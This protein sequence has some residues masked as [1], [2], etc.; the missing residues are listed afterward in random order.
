MKLPVCPH[1]GQKDV[2]RVE[3]FYRCNSCHSDFGRTAYSDDGTPMIE[4]VTGLRFQYGDVISGSVRLRFVQDGEVCLYEVYEANGKGINKHADVLSAEEW[5]NLK[6][7]LFEAL[8]V[9]DWDR[10]YIPVNDGREIMS[11]QAWALA[12]IVNDNEEYEYAGVDEKPIYWKQF[13]KLITP[14]LDNL[15]AE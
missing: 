4:A 2:T 12:V 3:D 10:F 11:N 5:M 13:E 14:F 6:K 1:C 8:Y 7:K 9:N 15:K